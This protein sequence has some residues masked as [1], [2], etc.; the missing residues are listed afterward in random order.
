MITFAF[1]AIICAVIGSVA[2]YVGV[3]CMR[4]AFE[5]S[6]GEAIGRFS[7]GIL[8][9]LAS[10]VTFSLFALC[11]KLFIDELKEKIKGDK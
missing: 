7:L 8:A 5:M 3:D 9:I 10:L 4:M 2:N 6:G 1:V 11:G